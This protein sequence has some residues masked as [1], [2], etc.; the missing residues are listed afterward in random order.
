M[1]AVTSFKEVLASLWM[2]VV[3]IACLGVWVFGLTVAWRLMRAIERIADAF[4]TRSSSKP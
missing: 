3:W 1:L 2:V 4:E